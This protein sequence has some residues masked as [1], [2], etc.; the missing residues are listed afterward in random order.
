[1]GPGS[2]IKDITAYAIGVLT[3]YSRKEQTGWKKDPEFAS[4]FA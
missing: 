2:D 1:M 4:V 3:A